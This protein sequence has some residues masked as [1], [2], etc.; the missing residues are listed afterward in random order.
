M[1]KNVFVVL[2][3]K[4]RKELQ[5][6]MFYNGKLEIIGYQAFYGC[7][8][9]MSIN[10][11]SVKI[12]ESWAFYCCKALTNVKF[13]KEL[14]SIRGGAFL[15]CTSLE[16]ITIPLKVG[17]ITDD[18]TFQECENLKH[19]D[20]IEGAV[21]RDTIAALLLE[22]WRNDMHEEIVSINQI[23]STTPDGSG[24]NEY[25][26][27]D[28]G[29]KA[30]AIRT[31]I[32]SVLRKILHYKAEHRRLLDEDVA[33]TLQLVLPQDIVMNSVLPFLEL[34]SYT[35]EVLVEDKEEDDNEDN[36]TTSISKPE[37]QSH[38]CQSR[39]RYRC[40]SRSRLRDKT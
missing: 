13:G 23:L 11:S 28:V 19:V 24:W 12:V 1:I 5:F 30:R 9:L 10:L 39:C 18:N 7:K 34:P 37:S 16:R 29:G 36:R 21:L 3:V 22:E 14:E 20:L 32:T 17:M 25:D 2:K 33:T 4:E 27:D 15:R 6:T 31:W 8:S 38:D 26:Y 35:F 40:I